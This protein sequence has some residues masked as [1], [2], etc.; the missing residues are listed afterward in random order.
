MTLS[1]RHCIIMTAYKDIETINRFISLTPNSW[2]IYIHLDKKS[3]LRASEINSR[4]KVVS[5][6]KI[7]WGGWEH[8]Y[9]FWHLLKFAKRE[10][11]KYDY[12]HLISGQDFYACP[13]SEFDKLLGY[14]GMSYMGLFPIPN[15]DWKWEGGY[16]IFKYRTLSSY[17]D[18]RN[19]IPR[20]INK[21]YYLLQ[22]Y[23]RMEKKLPNYPLYGSSVYCSLHNDF[24][25]WMV[26]SHMAE[27]LLFKLRNTLCA[28]E[29]FF[30]TVIMNSP[31][32]NKVKAEVTLRYVDWHS[33]PKPKFLVA[34]DFSKIKESNSLFC[35][36]VDSYTS[37]DLIPLLEN[38]IKSAN[39]E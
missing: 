9:A 37:K 8:L 6:K 1:M 5:I 27:S 19:A 39:N 22:K 25:E 26:N 23:T 7:Y 36:K 15:P 32:K 20:A 29:V 33:E 31:F 16:K 4:A 24:V 14:D 35:R 10:G 18:V 30:Q 38:Y 21:I 13:I 2:G 3:N 34:S 11:V 12:Y 17:C 28:E